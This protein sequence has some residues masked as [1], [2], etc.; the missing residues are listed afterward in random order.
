KKARGQLPEGEGRT[1]CVQCENAIPKDRRKAIPG[2]RRC[3]HCQSKLETH[4]QE[5]SGY[6]RRGNKD[7]QLR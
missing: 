5:S 1:H 2:V 4:Q 7:S 3:V 6:N